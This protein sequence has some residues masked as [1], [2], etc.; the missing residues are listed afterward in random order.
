M[1]TS[2]DFGKLILTLNGVPQR[3][4]RISTGKPA[5]ERLWYH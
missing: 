3:G 5:T 1:Q 4:E 2:K